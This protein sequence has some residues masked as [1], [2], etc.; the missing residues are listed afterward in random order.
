MSFK[1]AVVLDDAKTGPVSGKSSKIVLL[2]I[3]RGPSH[4]LLRIPS[5]IRSRILFPVSASLGFSFLRLILVERRIQKRD[6]KVATNIG[7]ATSSGESRA[8]HVEKSSLYAR[9][10]LFPTLLLNY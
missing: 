6:S 3:T 2:A 1:V 4:W 7:H 8:M 5:E 10:I 9:C